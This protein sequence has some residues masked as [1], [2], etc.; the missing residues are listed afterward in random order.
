[1]C[2][3]IFLELLSF[4]HFSSKFDSKTI[5]N[6]QGRKSSQHQQQTE[7]SQIEFTP[8]HFVLKSIE[9][10]VV[11][12]ANMHVPD[13]PDS[14]DPALVTKLVEELKSQGIFDE[15]RSECLSEVDSKVILKSEKSRHLK[16][17]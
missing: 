15:I 14:T 6:S 13:Q 7:K 9:V 5:Y 8:K 4:W 17:D 3:S 11:M 12:D 1:M 2:F 16:L 10:Q